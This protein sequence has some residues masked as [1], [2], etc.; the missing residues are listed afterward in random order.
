[1]PDGKG[2]ELGTTPVPMLDPPGVILVAPCELVGKEKDVPSGY[3][4]VLGRLDG[5]VPL[6]VGNENEVSP[7]L[8]EEPVPLAVGNENNVDFEL[9]RPPDPPAGIVK[10]AVG[11]DDDVPPEPEG[12][13]VSPECVGWGAVQDVEFPAVEGVPPAPEPVTVPVCSVGVPVSDPASGVVAVALPV[14]SLETPV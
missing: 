9:G 6:P 13:F 3:E 7:E 8:D 5:V 11:K 10:F 2:A 1:M 12:R 4:A 14:G